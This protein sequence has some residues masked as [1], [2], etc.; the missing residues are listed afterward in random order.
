M[1]TSAQGAII[2]YQTAKDPGDDTRVN[3]KLTGGHEYSG[4]ISMDGIGTYKWADFTEY[5]G[6]F[7]N[8]EMTG[9]ALLKFTNGIYSG[10]VYQGIRHGHGILILYDAKVKYIGEFCNGKRHGRGTLYYDINIQDQENMDNI[11]EDQIKKWLDPNFKSETY[12]DGSWDNDNRSGNGIC[13]YSNNNEYSGEWRMNEKHGKGIMKWS[14]YNEIYSGEW[15]DDEPNGN[16]IHIIFNDNIDNIDI[17]GITKHNFTKLNGLNWYYGEW[18]QGKR[19]GF[20]SYNYSNGALYRG[21]WKGNKKNGDGI[22]IYQ[23]GAKFEGEFI[24]D[25]QQYENKEDLNIMQKQI[26]QN[27]VIDFDAFEKELSTQQKD[28]MN[29]AILRNWKEIQDLFPRLNELNKLW[30]LVELLKLKD[31][32]MNLYEINKKIMNKLATYEQHKNNITDSQHCFVFREFYPLLI[33]LSIIA[34]QELE[35]FLKR[36]I[37]L[38]PLIGNNESDK[39]FWVSLPSLY[40]DS[41]SDGNIKELF[42]TKYQQFVDKTIKTEDIDNYNYSSFIGG[43]TINNILK[44]N[45]KDEAIQSL[46]IKQ[47]EM[48]YN[49]EELS[50][51]IL[52]IKKYDTKL[53]LESMKFLKH[54]CKILFIIMIS[55]KAAYDS[56]I[57]EKKRIEAEK[58]EQLELEREKAKQQKGKK[59]SKKNKKNK[60]KEEEEQVLNQN[61]VNEEE[62]IQKLALV[63]ITS[64]DL[65]LVFDE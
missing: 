15:I 59:G 40:C 38:R 51:E 21:E 33:R 30:K 1:D 64:N 54:E 28:E 11:D 17:D 10:H 37:E 41:W 63:S 45:I 16:G 6:D 56:Y 44:E 42:N 18:K 26:S 57:Q 9:F 58:E 47:F 52:V 24:N 32:E 35:V 46:I 29:K 50:S 4:P 39:S 48:Y 36:V 62:Q 13:R 2:N 19:D 65:N 43:D 23:N 8:G 60:D 55:I 5:S 14:A 49:S 7:Q 53:H 31:S 12:Y 34:K 3:A 22:Y 25:Q 61:E 20:G 27:F